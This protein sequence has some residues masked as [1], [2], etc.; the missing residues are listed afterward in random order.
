MQPAASAH[1]GSLH[2]H[3]E[4]WNGV[5]R[6]RFEG[7]L[8]LAS[9]DTVQRALSNAARTARSE[10]V[11]D[12]SGLAFIDSTGLSLLLRAHQRGEKGESAPIRTVGA[13]GVV[14]KVL[15]VSGVDRV[16]ANGSEGHPGMGDAEWQPLFSPQP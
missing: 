2:I 5:V 15:K 16:L 4:Q 10:V 14:A 6:L 7:E 8:D 13:R 12:L 11:V 9:E 3:A 1:H